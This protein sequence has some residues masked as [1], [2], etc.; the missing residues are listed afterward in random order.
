[1]RILFIIA[2][3]LSYLYATNTDGHFLTYLSDINQIEESKKE[4]SQDKT[5]TYTN[6]KTKV[7]EGLT[8][9]HVIHGSQKATSSYTPD[10]NPATWDE[11]PNNYPLETPDTYKNVDNEEVQSPT[12]YN[13][14]PEGASAICRD[15]TYSF[16]RNRRGTCSHHGGVAKWLK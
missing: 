12:N 16:S 4:S 10:S 9:K 15:G 3:A 8:D 11:D 6:N 14:I 5:Y 7:N 2:S 13:D 1:M